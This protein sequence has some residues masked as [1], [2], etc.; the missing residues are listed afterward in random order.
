[1]TSARTLMWFD[2]PGLARV[3]DANTYQDAVYLVMEYVEG[4]TLRT[5]LNETPRPDTAQILIWFEQIM[6]SLGAMHDIDLLHLDLKSSNIMVR[7]NGQTVLLDFGIEGRLLVETGFLRP[8]EIYCTPFYVS[9]ER[10][11]GEPPSVQSDLYALGVLF[12]EMLVGEKPYTG[13]SLSSILQQHL[14]EP[15]PDLPTPFA[16]YQPL[17]NSLMAKSLELRP[18]STYAALKMLKSYQTH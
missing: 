16:H 18:A 11:V 14:F 7:P 6:R 17:L 3:L 10:I 8:S 4:Q 1:M 9:P 12:Y 13:A 5:L 2:H 15:I